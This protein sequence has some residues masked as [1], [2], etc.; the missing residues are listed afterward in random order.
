MKDLQFVS[1]LN[2][3][4]LSRSKLSRFACQGISE[5][6]V[7]HCVDLEKL[8]DLEFDFARFGVRKGNHSEVEFQ[9]ERA[10]RLEI[11]IFGEELSGTNRSG[12]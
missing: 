11:L 6:G 12:S 2:S 5:N 9:P 7:H 10:L 1:F 3:V 4:Y 8:C